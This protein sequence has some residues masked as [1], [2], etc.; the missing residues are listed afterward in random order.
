ML[1]EVWPFVDAHRRSGRPVALARL[2]DRDGPGARPLGATLATAED[3]TWRGSLSGGCVEGIVLEAAR[4]VLAGGS[5]EIIAVNPGEQLLPWEEA[6]VCAGELRVLI[7]AAPPDPVHGAITTALAEDRVLAVRVGLRPPY[8]WAT[9]AEPGRLPDDGP[10]FTEELAVRPKLVLAG[11]TDLAAI[12]AVLAVPLQRR[13]VIVDPRVGHVT[14]G[15]FPGTAEVVRAWPDDWI[16]AHPL[17]ESDAVVSLSHDPRIDD[18]ALRAAL[19]GPAGYVAAL[20]SRATHTQRLRRLADARGVERLI[21]PAGLDLGGA[22]LAESA[23]SILAELA[24]VTNGRDGRRLR[25]G[26]HRIHAERLTA[27]SAARHVV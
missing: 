2:I 9:A 16:A 19:A 25:D 11:A 12:L 24:A 20:G 17:T 22:S 26:T 27:E 10:A 1:R 8:A 14:S 3:G 18:R 4:A 6:P 21:G 7:T 23:L 15:A 5:P 13:V